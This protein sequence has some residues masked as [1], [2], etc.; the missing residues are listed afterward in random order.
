MSGGARPARFAKIQAPE[1]WM[2]TPLDIVRLRER[3]ASVRKRLEAAVAGGRPI[4]ISVVTYYEMLRGSLGTR[5]ETRVREF[6]ARLSVLAWSDAAA[7]EAA[8]I[9][10]GLKERGTLIGLRA[11]YEQYARVC[12]C[13]GAEAAG[14]DFVK[15]G[16][17]RRASSDAPRLSCGQTEGRRTMS[18]GAFV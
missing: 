15:S 5:Y 8:R 3:P 12:P 18:S 17:G 10:R 6:V 2:N 9:W 7:E 13:A 16:L 11:R 1:S 14:L 4:V